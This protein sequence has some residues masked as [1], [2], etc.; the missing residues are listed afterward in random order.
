M[1]RAAHPM[2]RIAIAIESSD[3]FETSAADAIALA[4]GRVLTPSILGT[5]APLSFL[6]ESVP[7]RPYALRS[8]INLVDAYLGW[9]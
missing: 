5:G 2:T 8:C 3:A 9:E 6:P 4:D 1:S 7:G